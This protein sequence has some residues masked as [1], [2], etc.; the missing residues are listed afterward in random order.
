MKKVAIITDSGSDISYED[1]K[2]LG[3]EILPYKL[4]IVE[5]NSTYI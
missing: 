4:F 2:R 3:I 5:I 1:E